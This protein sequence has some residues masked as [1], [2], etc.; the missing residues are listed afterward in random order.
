MHV[1]D[2]KGRRGWDLFVSLCAMRVDNGDEARA[3]RAVSRV[4]AR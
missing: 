4:A 1:I 3:G 2:E